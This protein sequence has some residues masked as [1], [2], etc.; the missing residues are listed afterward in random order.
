MGYFLSRTEAQKDMNDAVTAARKSYFKH[1]SLNAYNFTFNE[2]SGS[3]NNSKDFWGTEKSENNTDSGK[4]FWGNEN[5]T[6][7]KTPDVKDNKEKDFWG[8]ISDTKKAKIDTL[9]IKADTLKKKTND[10][11]WK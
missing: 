5:N 4:D 6:N 7:E 9:K 2:S 10:D 3:G 1:I 11:F 8:N